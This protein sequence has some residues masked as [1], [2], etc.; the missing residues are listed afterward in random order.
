MP[1]DTE[2]ERK[3]VLYLRDVVG[4]ISKCSVQQ[5]IIVDD[6]LDLSRLD[7]NKIELNP[8]PFSLRSTISTVLQMFTPQIAQSKI[9]IVTNLPV[10]PNF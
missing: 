10:S 3:S 5:K 2:M 9:E 1:N 7:S 6:V 8:V 4:S